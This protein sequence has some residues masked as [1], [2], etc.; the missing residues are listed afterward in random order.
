MDWRIDLD[1]AKSLVGAKAIQGN[2]D[3]SILLASRPTLESRVDQL[4][5]S[6]PSRTGYI[7]NLGHGVLPETDYKQ[8]KHPVDYVHA[9]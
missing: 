6:L 1:R 3:P 5:E 2:L 7:F 4:F 8:L 9:K